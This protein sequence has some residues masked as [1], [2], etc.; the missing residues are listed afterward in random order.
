MSMHGAGQA[1]LRLPPF[2]LQLKHRSSSMH[3]K[4]SMR[5]RPA[6][7]RYV[8][9]LVP[10]RHRQGRLQGLLGAASRQSRRRRGAAMLRLHPR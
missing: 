4:R 2:Q 3:A 1:A 10:A 7:E 6:Q 8:R 5:L 9:L